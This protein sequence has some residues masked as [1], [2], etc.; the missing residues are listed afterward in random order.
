MAWTPNKKTL[1][2]GFLVVSRDLVHIS[3]ETRW[4][5]VTH[6]PGSLPKRPKLSALLN[7]VAT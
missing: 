4:M 2:D 6:G 3:D 1:P 7:L 5:E